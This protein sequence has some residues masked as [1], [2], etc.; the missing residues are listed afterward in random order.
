MH[1]FSLAVVVL[2]LAVSAS[3]LTACGSASSPRPGAT[4]ASNSAHIA[5]HRQKPKPRR[6]NAVERACDTGSD[7]C[8]QGYDDCRDMAKDGVIRV[9]PNTATDAEA[10]KYAK[11]TF[12]GSGP[13]QAAM[14]GCLAALDQIQR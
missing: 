1:S 3:S 6:K 10:L 11:A 12:G 9:G 2:T 5:A 14:T 13:W 7:V 8:I 4:A